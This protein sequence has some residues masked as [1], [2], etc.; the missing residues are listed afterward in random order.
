[1]SR[2]PCYPYLVTVTFF[3]MAFQVQAAKADEAMKVAVRRLVRQLDASTLAERDE[4]EEKLIKLGP[5]AIDLLPEPT[6]RM[7]AE[8]KQ[9]LA[10]VRQKLEQAAADAAVQASHVTL[11]DPAIPL[12]KCLAAITKQTGNKIIDLRDR[13]GQPKN[14]PTLKVKFNKTPFWEAIDEVCRQSGTAV[15]PFGPE[16]AVCLM[17]RPGDQKPASEIGSVTGPFRI[18]P[19]EFF[20][21]RN[22]IDPKQ[23]SLM[24]KLGIL[25]EPRLAPVILTQPLAKVKAVDE[26]GQPVATGR[27]PEE[28]EVTINP[29]NIAVELTVPLDLPSRDV[30]EIAKFT[31]S[32]RTLLPGR[33]AT[34]RF[35]NLLKAKDVKQRKAGAQVMLRQVRKNNEVWEVWIVVKFDKA[36][37]ALESHRDWIYQNEAY[38]E[39]P[40]GKKIDNDG[41]ETAQRGENEIGLVYLFAI[42]ESLAKCKF[43]YKT[44][45]SLVGSS[46]QY[47]LKGLKLP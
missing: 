41:Y 43:V 11:D 46:V 30:K 40:D 20:A 25:W 16:R 35:D 4:A 3:M 29:D 8:V 37:D 17:T 18:M 28:L 5:E 13:F 33:V 34:F 24:L 1:M 19:L 44:P 23:S 6:G 36:G 12:S 14:D 27:G 7:S 38:L 42:E 9:R 26:R 47:E 32:L 39:G 10:R 22:L 15:Y 45:G 2:F 31:G 21:R